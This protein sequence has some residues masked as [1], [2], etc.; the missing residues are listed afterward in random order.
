MSSRNNTLWRLDRKKISRNLGHK[1]KQ[2]LKSYFGIRTEVE[3]EY[4]IVDT[5]ENIRDIIKGS[6][7]LAY[8]I[9]SSINESPTQ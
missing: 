5:K 1:E 4:Y 6:A 3:S 9:H 7:E 8:L 2:F